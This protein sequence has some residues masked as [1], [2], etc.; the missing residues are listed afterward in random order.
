[1][2]VAGWEIKGEDKRKRPVTRISSGDRLA[3]LEDGAP[4][5]VRLDV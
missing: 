3:E 2:T 5:R 4:R 1:M